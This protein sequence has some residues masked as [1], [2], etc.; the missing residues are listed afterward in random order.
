MSV[1]QLALDAHLDKKTVVGVLHGRHSA[2]PN[3]LKKLADV[4]GVAASKLA[5]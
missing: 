4:L 5:S 3:T 1:E 2:T